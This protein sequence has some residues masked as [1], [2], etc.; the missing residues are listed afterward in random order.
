MYLVFS[1]ADELGMRKENRIPYCFYLNQSFPQYNLKKQ[2]NCS[3]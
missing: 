1:I 3:K 2:K